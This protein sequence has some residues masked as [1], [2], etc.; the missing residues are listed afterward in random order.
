LFIILDL[1]Y[2]YRRMSHA[3]LAEDHRDDAAVNICHMG[4][5]ITPGAGPGDPDEVALVSSLPFSETFVC[6]ISSLIYAY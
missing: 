1:L 3:R 5:K 2:V 6:D 4:A